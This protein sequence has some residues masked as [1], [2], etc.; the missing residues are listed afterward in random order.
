MQHYV[1][2]TMRGSE[3]RFLE[4]FGERGSRLCKQ[5]IAQGSKLT[6]ARTWANQTWEFE[7]KIKKRNLKELCPLCSSVAAAQVTK[8]EGR[9][10]MLTLAPR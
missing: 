5:A 6:L 4:H 3:T 2:G 8:E 1:G 7:K 10:F 9:R